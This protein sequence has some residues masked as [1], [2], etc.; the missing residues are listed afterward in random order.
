MLVSHCSEHL[1]YPW[2]RCKLGQVYLGEERSTLESWG[3]DCHPGNHHVHLLSD[4]A[5]PS[6]GLWLACLLTF[7]RTERVFKVHILSSSEDASAPYPK[8]HAL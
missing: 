5:K 2:V 7:D 6:L 8:L 4:H 1:F 3:V